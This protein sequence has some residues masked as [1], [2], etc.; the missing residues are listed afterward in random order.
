[1]L[2]AHRENM[3]EF[4]TLERTICHADEMLIKYFS[5]STASFHEYI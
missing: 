1:M 4:R 5:V 2:K 3:S